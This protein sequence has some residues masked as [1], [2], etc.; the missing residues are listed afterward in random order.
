MG[1]SLWDL[2]LLPY[3]LT[4]HAHPNS[5]RF[6]GQIGIAFFVLIPALIVGLWKP[7]SPRWIYLTVFFAVLFLFWFVY[8]QYVRFL[9]PAFTVLT[10]LSAAGLEKITRP[11]SEG[12][13]TPPWLGRLLLGVVACA[14]SFNLYLIW[15]NWQEK[16]PGN[17]VVGKETRDQYLARSIPRYPM[18]QAMN[19]LPLE[20]KVLFV[21]MRNLGY[22][23][24]RP[25]H[26]DSVFEAHTLQ[27]LLAQD[28]SP[29]GLRRQLQSLGIT[30]LMF[31]SK[32]VFGKQTAFP[33]D[34]Q[35]VLNRLLEHRAR[36]L[37][38]VDDFFLYQ[39][40]LD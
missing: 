14:V 2:M 9:A 15:N 12:G 7:R 36:L 22:L 31:D 16:A 27:A 32:Y 35:T 40:V 29:D 34:H 17:Y 10:L 20:S 39:L 23:A 30:H 6:D 37:H 1:R 19:K 11:K 4:F 25:F 18:Y 28:P 24:E 8:F 21:Y 5:L 26:S 3:N 38:R 33:P 13:S